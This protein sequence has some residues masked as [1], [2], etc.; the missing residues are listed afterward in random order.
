M[1][2]PLP[3]ISCLSPVAA[4]LAAAV[5]LNAAG[6]A[7]GVAQDL[8][9]LPPGAQ[10]RWASAENPSGAKGAGA[11]TNEGRKG[12]PSFAL[13]AGGTRV[14][15]EAAGTSGI[16][17]RIWLT[18]NH[19]DPEMLRGLRID[20]F[21]DG[22]TKPAVSA[23]LGDFFGSGL[24]RM[25]RIES[26]LF[27][28]PEGRSFNCFIPMPFRTGMKIVL[29]NETARPVE[30]VFYDVDY[31]IGDVLGDDALY[32]HAWF[33]REN[34]TEFLRDYTILPRVAGRGRFLGVNLGVIVNQ[35]EFF[36]SWW[37]EGEVKMYLDGDGPWPTLAGT[38]TE[39]Y[40]GSAWGLG[41]FSSAYSGCTWDREYRFCFYRWHV[42]DPVYFRSD[43]RVTWQQIGLWDPKTVPLFRS[44]GRAYFYMKPDQGI[45]WNNPKLTTYGLME[46]R[47]DVS[48]CAYFYLDGPT[49]D[50]P[51]LMAVAKRTAGLGRE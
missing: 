17:R 29:T 2:S 3:R 6:P 24:G 27:A 42:P 7:C 49:D 13:P 43:L 40:V 36:T 44:A 10:T 5:L 37:G 19:R 30:M 1:K 46:R 26:A 32:L 21:W 41:A 28:S 38:G 23:P 14:L 22:A 25:S 18:V 33:N 48:S 51:P 12:S 4:A 11:Q 20:C 15:A 39:D 34:P 8:Y 47:D 16:V 35:K 9:R 31:T 45:D 50:L